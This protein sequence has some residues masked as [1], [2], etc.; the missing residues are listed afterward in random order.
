MGAGLG[1][2]VARR[3]G[4]TRRERLET[5]MGVP[6]IRRVVL[7]AIFRA[8]PRAVRRRALERER[9]VIEWRIRGGPEEHPDVRQLVIEDGRSSVLRGMKRE[10]DLSLK[11]DGLTCLLLATGQASG[12]TLFVHGHI[13]I[14]GDPWL[15]MRL[16]KL[17]AVPR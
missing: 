8:M 1:A 9:V 16:P 15:A 14:D 4:S 5:L 11:M 7:W 2:W 10:P 3:V 6:L 17:F 12:P 13:E